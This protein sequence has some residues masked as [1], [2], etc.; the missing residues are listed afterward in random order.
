MLASRIT[1]CPGTPIAADRG[2]EAGTATVL[3]TVGATKPAYGEPATSD[4]ASE[5]TE[6]GWS[7]KSSDAALRSRPN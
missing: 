4:N 5:I 2:K 6:H 3:M 7:V 1:V